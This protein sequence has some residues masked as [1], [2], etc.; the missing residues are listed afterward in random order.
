[1]AAFFAAF[2]AFFAIAPD[3]PFP[4]VGCAS[5]RTTSGLDLDRL[6]R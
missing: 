2:L 1:L 6:A 3:P 5:D 4:G